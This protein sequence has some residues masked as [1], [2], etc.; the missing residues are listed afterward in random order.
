MPQRIDD[1]SDMKY[2]PDELLPKEHIDFV[3]NMLDEAGIPELPEDEAAELKREIV[4]GINFTPREIMAMIDACMKHPIKLIV[5]AL[6]APPKELVER[7]HA[8]GIKVGGLA[9]K[10]RHAIKHRDVGC[11]FV[12]A[13]GT[14]AG[15][16][17]GDV[18]SMVLWPSIVDAVAPMPVLGAGGVG[19]GGSWRRRWCWAAKACG[20]S[21]SGSRPRRAK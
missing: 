10:P 16:Y 11:D 1:T 14:E 7:A 3:R 6:G 20:P 17:T 9:G 13:V 8:R 2:D 5:N 19:A 4:K 18:S 12:V 15:G 21:R